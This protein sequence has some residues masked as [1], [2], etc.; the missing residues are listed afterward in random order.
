MINNLLTNSL[1]G[2]KG[3]KYIDVE[4]IKLLTKH[5]YYIQLDYSFEELG[6][7]FFYY[8]L[9]YSLLVASDYYATSEFM[10]QKEMDILGDF[11]SIQDF[12][13]E[14]N[15]NNL[16]KSI[17]NYE[18]NKYQ[19][20]YKNFSDIT[21]INDLRSELFLDAEKSLQKKFR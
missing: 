17:R 3:L 6:I 16:L 15:Q 20:Q 19:G 12:Q 11:L 9:A 4:K 1:S 21:E 7:R 5:F 10:N 8:R 18:K 13:K 2:Y 14:Y